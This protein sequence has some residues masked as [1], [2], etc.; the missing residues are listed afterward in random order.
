MGQIGSCPLVTFLIKDFECS[1][2]VTITCWFL[3][4]LL[5]AFTSLSLVFAHPVMWD[6]D[7]WSECTRLITGCIWVVN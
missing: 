5:H 1:D 6:I 2:T 3:I 4:T 7:C